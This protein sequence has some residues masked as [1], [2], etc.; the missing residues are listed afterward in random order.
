MI[1]GRDIGKDAGGEGH[2]DPS[3]VV[4]HPYDVVFLDISMPGRSGVEVAQALVEQDDAPAVVFVTAHD[5]FALQAFEVSALDYLVKPVEAV[6]LAETV[7]R[8][9]TE[10]GD[11]VC[12]A[13]VKK[14]VLLNSHGGNMKR[15]AIELAKDWR[16]DKYLRQL[17]AIIQQWSARQAFS[18]HWD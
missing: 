3:R 5:Q 14:L 16:M 1:G 6:R 17:Q 7:A 12:R 15:A 18:K 8:L 4:E 9:W 13:G 11:S 2:G 10:V